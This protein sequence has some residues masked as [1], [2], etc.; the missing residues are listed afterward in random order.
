LDNVGS[1]IVALGNLPRFFF[2]EE[3]GAIWLALAS[4]CHFHEDA[5]NRKRPVPIVFHILDTPIEFEQDLHVEACSWALDARSPFLPTTVS[6]AHEVAMDLKSP[7]EVRTNVV[8]KAESF[9]AFG[10]LFLPRQVVVQTYGKLNVQGKLEFLL[11]NTYQIKVLEAKPQAAR[12]SFRPVLSGITRIVERR[13][14]RSKGI[15]FGFTTTSNRWPTLEA[16]RASQAYKEAMVEARVSK[17]PPLL[18]SHKPMAVFTAVC[19]ALAITAT[20]LI[21]RTKPE[22]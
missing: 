21:R 22:S 4:T 5:Q 3:A 6:Y 14:T 9:T 7:R 16:S 11:V 15:T 13:F 1:A 8:L 2:M 10:P 12:L 19:A 18:G 17:K 20:Y